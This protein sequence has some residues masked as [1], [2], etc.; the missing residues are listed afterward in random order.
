MRRKDVFSGG[1]RGDNFRK[2]K[3]KQLKPGTIMDVATKDVVA[4][5]P[6]STIMAAVKAMDSYGFR[7]LPI[8]DAGTKRLEGIM[9][10]TD[11]ISFFGGGDK[12]LIVEEKYGNN[13]LAAVNEEVREVLERN[14]ITVDFTASLE[15]GL[16]VILRRGVGGCPVVDREDRVVGIVTERDYLEYLARMNVNGEVTGYMSRAVITAKPESSIRDAMRTMIS[17]KIRRLPVIKD[18]VLVGLITSSTLVRFFS[19]EAFRSIITGDASDVLEKPLSYL[20]SNG[21]ILEYPEPLTLG[22]D[23][24]MSEAARKMIEG[25]HGA[26]LIVG[27]GRL[28]GI[29]TERDVVRFIYRAR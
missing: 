24:A 2:A 26:A 1:K 13:L 12:H 6:T 18:G 3:R 5:P 20:L 14:V 19:G 11:I 23:T 27:N 28:E 22:L 8:A 21:S 16:E 4:I 9:T 15:E 29:L 7:R 25:N 10:A 17:R